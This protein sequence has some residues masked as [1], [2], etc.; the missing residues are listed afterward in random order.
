MHTCLYLDRY[1]LHISLSCSSTK[2]LDSTATNFV[3]I[4]DN[5]K[6][7]RREILA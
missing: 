2:Q 3:C 1:E 7:S 6:F 4:G 5:W